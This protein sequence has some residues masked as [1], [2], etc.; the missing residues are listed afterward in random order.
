MSTPHEG[1]IVMEASPPDPFMEALSE[2][3]D[4]DP[5]LTMNAAVATHG[6]Q[7]GVVAP[8]PDLQNLSHLHEAIINWML[9]NPARPLRECAKYFGY[10]QAWLSIIIHSGLFQARLKERQ[11][12][13]FN[14]TVVPLADKLNAAAHI[15]VEKLT[16]KLESSEDPKFILEGAKTALA[17][18]GFGG[19]SGK[20]SQVVNAANV[21]QNFYVASPAD[22][23]AARGRMGQIGTVS[24]DH[25]ALGDATPLLSAPQG[26]NA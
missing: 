12:E 20:N 18:L 14:Q 5:K 13:I 17:S 7:E 24:P 15:A 19:G 25:P 8:R 3:F 21:Q 1:K 16:E 26:E 4:Q 10:S 23:E 9:V 22:L 6:L 2:I 11:D